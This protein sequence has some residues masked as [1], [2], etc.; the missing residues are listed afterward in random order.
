MSI[1]L[2]IFLFIIGFAMGGAAIW[3]MRQKK[4]MPCKRMQIK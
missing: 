3:F 1:G 4:W 2:G